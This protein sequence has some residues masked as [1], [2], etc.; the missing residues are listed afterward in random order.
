MEPYTQSL[1][2]LYFKLRVFKT[3][4]YATTLMLI[5]F[6]D[7]VW[8]LGW[9]VDVFSRFFQVLLY[10]LSSSSF[11]LTNWLILLSCQFGTDNN[12]MTFQA[13]NEIWNNLE[14]F[15]YL[16]RQNLIHEILMKLG[17]WGMQCVVCLLST[18]SLV[19]GQKQMTYPSVYVL[20]HIIYELSFLSH[21]TC[22]L[23]AFFPLV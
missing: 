9:S 20:L 5:W 17:N 14:V 19:P 23:M 22:R 8:I 13:A 3:I 11:N 1:S 7:A 12:Y 6:L 15:F 10:L 4:W 18:R 2:F 16:I 21:V